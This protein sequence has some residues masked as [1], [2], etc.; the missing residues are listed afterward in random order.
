MNKPLSLVLLIFLAG[1]WTGLSFMLFF[2]GWLLPLENSNLQFVYFIPMFPL[3][4]SVWI[5]QIAKFYQLHVSI[6]YFFVALT[7]FMISLI[8]LILFCL[9]GVAL[10]KLLKDLKLF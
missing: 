7:T 2:I 4:V 8:S 9:I 10:K 5:G 3:L 1:C 6:Q